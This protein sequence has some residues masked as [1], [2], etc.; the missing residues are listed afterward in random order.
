L[1]KS[2]PRSVRLSIQ[3]I[4]PPI[5]AATST[6]NTMATAAGRM[7]ASPPSTRLN[8]SRNATPI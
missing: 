6:A 1:S 8:E 4:A 7:L 3:P 2:R 5:A